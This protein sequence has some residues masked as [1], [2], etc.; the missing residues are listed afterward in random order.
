MNFIEA[1][2]HN[3]LSCSPWYC[4]YKQSVDVE[5]VQCTGC[6]FGHQDQEHTIYSNS[7]EHRMKIEK[8]NETENCPYCIDTSE[9]PTSTCISTRWRCSK[10]Q[11]PIAHRTSNKFFL[12]LFRFHQKRITF[13][14]RHLCPK[15]PFTHYYYGSSRCLLLNTHMLNRIMLFCWLQFVQS[16]KHY[17]P[18]FKRLHFTKN[19]IGHFNDVPFYSNRFQIGNALTIIIK[20]LWNR[21]CVQKYEHFILFL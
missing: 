14:V 21:F 9:S 17:I 2:V 5:K 11:W 1:Y 7:M 16:M 13:S 19:Y 3:S 18:I 6:S 15:N 8:K 10:L 4:F 20:T 12:R